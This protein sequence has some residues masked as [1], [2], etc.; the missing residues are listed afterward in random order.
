[1]GGKQYGALLV[2]LLGIPMNAVV[3]VGSSAIV[4]VAAADFFP[5]QIRFLPRGLLDTLLHSVAISYLAV[6]AL[7]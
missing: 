3:A 2:A 6:S 4:R 7:L 5:F 1:M